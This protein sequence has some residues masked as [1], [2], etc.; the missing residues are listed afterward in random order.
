MDTSRWPISSVAGIMAIIFYLVFTLTSFLHYPTVYSPFTNWLS[1]LGN[2]QLNPSG[3]IFYNVGVILTGITILP[4][5]IGLYKWNT[6]EKRMK[7]LLTIAQLAGISSALSLIM[8]G[9]FPEDYPEAHW[10]W[11]T[12]LFVSFAFF[13]T[14][15]AGSLVKHPAF[16]KPI[17]YYGFTAAVINFMS[18]VI[19]NL[20]FVGEW[21]SVSMF[22]IYVVLLV[23][24]F[25]VIKDRDS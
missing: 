6:G 1:D 10:F 11:S 25:K 13:L 5:Y 7:I 8:V 20:V 16:I 15:S 18:E 9:V 12:I 23:Y 2:S 22:I 19:Y 21:I 14:F 24:N 3:A 17:A 4:F